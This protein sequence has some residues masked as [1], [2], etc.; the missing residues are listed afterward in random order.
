MSALAAVLTV[1]G[2]A[3]ISEH[4]H[5]YLGSPQYP[6]TNPNNVLV[7]A[8]EPKEPKEPLGEII[9]WVQGDPSRQQL[10]AKLREAAA[11]LGADAVFIASDR[12][13]IHPILYWDWWGPA[14]TSEEWD[15]HVVG[16]AI[17]FK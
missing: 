3:S 16:V 2:C 1:C 13:H 8:A 9:L 7:L 11:R 5:A 17:K 14:G 6:P 10:E 15:R 4:T 12:T